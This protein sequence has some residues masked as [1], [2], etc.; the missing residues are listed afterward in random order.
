MARPRKVAVVT[1]PVQA[2]LVAH[3]FEA[4][5]VVE[6]VKAPSG[7]WRVT[8]AAWFRQHGAEQWLA[9]GTVIDEAVVGAAHVAAL[10]LH[11]IAL[12]E[13]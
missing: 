8:K 2:E 1:E 6:P 4:S 5:P 13:V 10:K 3:V 12:E 9:V 7:R 11:R